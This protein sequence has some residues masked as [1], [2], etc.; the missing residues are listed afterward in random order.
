MTIEGMDSLRK[1]LEKTRFERAQHIAEGLAQNRAL[2]TT[3]ELARINQIL[4]GSNFELPEHY[5]LWRHEPVTITLPSGQE[6]TLALI[7]DPVRTAREKLHRA[8]EM[9]ENGDAVDAAIDIYVH[10]VLAHVFKDANRRT[11]VLAAH[12][13]LRRYG[14]TISGP[15]IHELGLGDL[16]QEGQVELFRKTVHKMA[17]RWPS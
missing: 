4:T 15:A 10:L 13:F 5:R 9:A 3:V 12:Y 1:Q 16:R 17:S 2:L 6:E 8:T 14:S 11:A 7:I